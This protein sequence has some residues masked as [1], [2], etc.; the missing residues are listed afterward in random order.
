MSISF[1]V[2]PLSGA[3]IPLALPLIQATWPGAD[4]ASWS[5]FVEFFNEPM[6]A[7]GSG[8]LA[9]HDAAGFICGVLAYRFDRDLQ[10]GAVLAVHLFTVADLVNSPKTVRV[11]ID[12]A[13][14]RASEL[15][16]LGVQIR[17]RNDQARLASRLRTLG[18]SSEADLFWKKVG[19]AHTRN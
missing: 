14:A 19:P 11:L 1:H 5:G 2:A 13:E 17:L 7:T 10:A 16:C 8:V 12:A 6:V 3:E 15:G 4:L 18:L 9:L